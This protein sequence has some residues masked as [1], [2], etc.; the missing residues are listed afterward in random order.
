MADLVSQLLPRVPLA[1]AAMLAG[2]ADQPHVSREAMRLTG[3]TP[4]RLL[5]WQH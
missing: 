2:Y 4:S 1:R 5:T 3:L